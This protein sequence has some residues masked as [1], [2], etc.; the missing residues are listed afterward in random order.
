MSVRVRGLTKRYGDKP[1]LLDVDLELAPGELRGLLGPNGAGKTTLLRAMFGLIRP[2]AGTVEL[3]GRTVD[4]R[5]RTPLDGVA[6]FVEDPAFYP[7]LSGAA[8]LQLLA[9]LDDRGDARTAEALS[10]VGL[11]ARAD[12]R[13]GGYS[14]GMRQR[15][16]IAAALLREPRVLLLDEPTSGLDPAGIR[17]VSE[18]L[19][20]L[21]ADG[22][23]VLISSHLIGEL[24]AICH[25]YTIIAG[26]RV[27]W[28]GSSTRLHD[29]APGSVYT[30]ATSDD[31]RALAL[32]EIAE[33]VRAEPIDGTAPAL[34]ITARPEAL[35]RYA[36]A[37]G[38]EDIAV[39]RLELIVSP[40]ERMYFSLTGADNTPAE[41]SEAATA[42]AKPK[43]PTAASAAPRLGPV[44]SAARTERRKLVAQLPL[45]LLA[46]LSL[47]GPFL[48]AIL[49]KLQS[50]TPSDALFGVWVHTSGFA[51]SLVVLGFAANWGFPIIA[52][53]L[54]G[55]LF[56]SE[57]RH[58][59]WKT[60]L[61]RSR[62]LDEEFAGKALAAAQFTLALGV[63]LALSS[64]LAGVILVGDQPLVDLSGQQL[65]AGH[66]W[67]LVSVSW[68]I[69]LLP[70]LAYASLA[71]LFSVATRNGI[72]G[73]LG[74]VL[75]ALIT[76]L[77]AL[78]GNGV[79]VHLLLIGSC[80]DAWH[81]LFV[82][83]AFFGPLVV[84]VLVCAAWIAGAL[85][86]ARWILRRRE[87]V[88]AGSA[89]RGGGWRPAVRIAATATALIAVLALATNLGPTGVTGRRLSAT[90][91]PEFKRLVILQQKLLGHPIP[92]GA[93][94]HIVPVCGK[95]SARPVGPGDWA[96]T[97][98]VYI[99][100]PGGAQPLTDTPVAYDVSVQS[101]GCYKAQSP[102]LL[103][104]Q[105]VIHDTAHQ[106][107][108]NPIVT[109][110]G[111][112]NVV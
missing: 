77:L 91:A 17:A 60:I 99:L 28:D 16:G 86:A 3:L 83:H 80:Y 64:L 84:A 73:V 31:R 37:L 41:G 97:M 14:T 10:R 98:N 50:G 26:G 36:I 2:D 107:V 95:R 47:I 9:E 44:R 82:D 35:D 69:A 61:T 4:H 6:G 109:I 88:S 89:P 49:L 12:D 112:F 21:A 103:V 1:A 33:G 101:N 43:P 30:L 110:Y 65:G 15:L 42:P 20:E 19:R 39:R 22:V 58:G 93:R 71:I 79:W 13:V 81:G 45:R 111:C 32:A 106:V 46:V 57:D 24:E 23:A 40:L 25:S 87:F 70:T 34:R 96:C 90:I 11:T 92:P 67:L 18:L 76:Q 104:G 5:R 8:N 72:V 27:V 38:H 66:L 56:A 48:F 52:G 108:V 78:L 100:L 51:I 102:P 53:V 55:D 85:G 94:Y 105:A 7:Y 68:L 54:A 63:L 59:T 29:E 75:V 74:P 62:T